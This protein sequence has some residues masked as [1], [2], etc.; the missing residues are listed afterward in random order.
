M[1]E[2]VSTSDNTSANIRL[3]EEKEMVVKGKKYEL[4]GSITKSSDVWKHFWGPCVETGDATKKEKVICQYKVLKTT[5]KGE[6]KCCEEILS[7]CKNTSNLKFEKLPQ[8]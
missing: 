8:Y 6:K 3:R 1:S 4:Q 7:F 2:E 5:F